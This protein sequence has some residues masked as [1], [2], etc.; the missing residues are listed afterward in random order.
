MTMGDQQNGH[1]RPAGMPAG[2]SQT[3]SFGETAIS[4]TAETAAAA[5]AAQAQ[6][7]IQARYVMAMQRPRDW[8][9]VRVKLLRACERTRFADVARYRKPIGQGIEGPSIRFAEEAV[10]C[11]TNILPETTVIFDDAEKRILRVGVTDLEGNVSY[12]TEIVVE[13][14]VE[15]SKV[16]EGQT[17][18]RTRVNSSNKKTYLVEATEDDILNKVNALVSKALRTNALRLLPG[19]ILDECMDKI[20]ETQRNQDIKDPDASRK[21]IVDGFASINVMPSDLKAYLGHDIA[22]S[23]PAELTE[24][25]GV[26]A[27]IRDGE[28]TWQAAL[29]HKTGKSKAD[30]AGKASGNPGDLRDRVRQKT[31]GQKPPA[32][33][34]PAEPPP[35]GRQPGED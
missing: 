3:E 6:A 1:G 19:D 33:A 15:R 8:D 35:A 7:A 31:A 29:D 16:K 28:A 12:L 13:K 18:I 4:R 26:F 22:A 17:V 25:R 14:T 2:M 10:R 27:A 34:G 24:L 30:D 23:S 11:M 32:D 9:N 20:V 21:K 5:V